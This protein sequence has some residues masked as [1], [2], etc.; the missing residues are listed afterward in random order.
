[1]AFASCVYKADMSLVNFTYGSF[2]LCY[3]YHSSEPRNKETLS[4]IAFSSSRPNN[5]SRMSRAAWFKPKPGKSPAGRPII[6]WDTETTGLGAAKNSLVE[7]GLTELPCTAP[8]KSVYSFSSLIHPVG[9]T[10][11]RAAS[12]VHGITNPMMHDAPQFA[13]VWAGVTEYVNQVCAER[14]RPVLVAHNLGFDLSFLKEELRR[15]GLQL[16]DWDFACSLRDVANVLWPG[17]KSSLAALAE[18]F[19][20]V[21][22]EAHRALCDVEATGK[23]LQQADKDL[24]EAAQHAGQ[25]LKNDGEYIR[26]MLEKAAL[27]RRGPIHATP[28]QLGIDGQTSLSSASPKSVAPAQDSIKDQASLCFSS[29]KAVTP[30]VAPILQQFYVSPSGFLW[31]SSRGCERL[32]I[33]NVILRVT[34]RPTEKLQCNKCAVTSQVVYPKPKESVKPAERSSSSDFTARKVKPK[35]YVGPTTRQSPSD[36]KAKPTIS[37]SINERRRSLRIKNQRKR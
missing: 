33:A 7:I 18:R 31:H 2:S 20:I 36:S 4:S 25:R 12:R 23:V 15:I 8:S 30:F 10:M 1:M 27:K 6:L 24:K 14:G 9:V 3:P 37:K 28:V 11:P 13:E 32:D 21:N 22:E 16:P 19:A 17:Q 35:S 26:E 29:R 34:R 5:A